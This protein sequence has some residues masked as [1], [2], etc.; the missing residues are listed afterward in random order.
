MSKL[1]VEL[2][3]LSQLL[4]ATSGVLVDLAEEL[5]RQ[6]ATGERSPALHADE[7]A[8]SPEAPIPASGLPLPLLE[9]PPG[10]PM[11]GAP[12]DPLDEVIALTEEIDTCE[13]VL[14]TMEPGRR[15]AQVALWAGRAREIQERWRTSPHVTKAQQDALRR[16]FGR[17]TRITREHACRWIDALTTD[18]TIDWQLYTS[19][20]QSLVTGEDAE[21]TLDQRQTYWKALL[22]G[23]VLP[24][25]YVAPAEASDIIR[26]ASAVLHGE[27]DDLTAAIKRFGPARP[28]AVSPMARRRAESGVPSIPTL[29]VPVPPQ[30]LEL[31]RGK[32]AAL[33]GGQQAREEHRIVLET[34]F[35]LD[36]LEWEPFSQGAEVSCERM[37]HQLQNRAFDLIFFLVGYTGEKSAVLLRQ[38]RYQRVPIVFLSRGY[39]VLSAIQS[40]DEQLV[41]PRATRHAPIPTTT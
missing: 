35:Q 10:T 40:V 2:R 29:P 36:T 3:R 31:T 26:E 39:G 1:L 41:R 34:T 15:S 12:G 24:R 8:W 30:V 23:L 32:R 9:G 37:V 28:G 22:R 5:D 14:P 6:E 17:L 19:V 38:A 27:D 16:A 11:V 4:T 7:S 33:V 20:N 21:L 18:W 13:F 25:R